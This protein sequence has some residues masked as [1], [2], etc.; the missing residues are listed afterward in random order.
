MLTHSLQ[1]ANLNC[2]NKDWTLSD[3]FLCTDTYFKLSGASELHENGFQMEKQQP[4]TQIIW[5]YNFKVSKVLLHVSCQGLQV[6]F[7]PRNS[8]DKLSSLYQ[9]AFLNDHKKHF[10]K[11]TENGHDD[12]Q[13]NSILGVNYSWLLTFI[14]QTGMKS[15]LCRTL[16]KIFCN[17]GLMKLL[18]VNA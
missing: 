14:C 1:S 13:V 9:I 16:S 8:N 15:A 2:H 5:L 4:F 18:S 17:W 12:T 7:L 11:G 10:I 6:S 3:R